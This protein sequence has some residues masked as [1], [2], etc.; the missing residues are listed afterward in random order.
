VAA[1]I[2]RIEAHEAS[3]WAQAA[4]RAARVAGILA[5]QAERDATLP[6]AGASLAILTAVEVLRLSRLDPLRVLAHPRAGTVLLAGAVALGVAGDF[7]QRGNFAEKRAELRAQLGAQFADIARLDPPP[8]DALDRRAFPPHRA[9][10]LQVT[11]DAI[12]V[13]G[14]GVAPLA[15]LDSPEGASHVAAEL[16][17]ALAQAILEQRSTKELDLS[18]SIDREVDGGAL[19]GLLRIARAA[20]MRRIEVLLTRGESPALGR[21]GPPEI[22]VVVPNDFVALPAELADT[23]FAL[24]AGQPFGR[25]APALTVEALAAHGPILLAVQAPRR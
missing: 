12:A 15:A 18:V 24:P 25:I 23:G 22:G 11:R 14:R 8:G 17:R 1:G 4:T 10:A 3:L 6:I 21:G 16:N 5:A 7:V 19:L 20:G 13:D 2:T 9:T